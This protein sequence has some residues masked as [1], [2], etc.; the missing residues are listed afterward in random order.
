M[1]T[2]GVVI[3][4]ADHRQDTEKQSSFVSP[5]TSHDHRDANNPAGL[6]VL[7]AAETMAGIL[8]AKAGQAATQLRH[9]GTTLRRSAQQD[10][11]ISMLS[12]PYRGGAG[13]Q[14]C[15][16]WPCADRHQLSTALSPRRG[17]SAVA[18]GVSGQALSQGADVPNIRE[19]LPE[20][21]PVRPGV[22]ILAPPTPQEIATWLNEEI[23]KI[24]N[25]PVQHP[26]REQPRNHRQYAGGVRR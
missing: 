22:G 5:R 17:A 23:I 1:A 13:L 18:H 21:R 2:L 10:G 20:Y 4:L 25:T 14:R 7:A 6:L 16:G 24:L 3:A 11:G 8:A 15:A 9:H 19:V 26:D 12:V